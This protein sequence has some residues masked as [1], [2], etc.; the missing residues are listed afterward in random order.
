MAQV[1]REKQEHI[2]PG[3]AGSAAALELR[4]LS[5]G[6]NGRLAIA[7]INLQLRHRERMALVG[8]NGAGKSTLFKSIVGLMP[9]RSGEI[10]IH[11]K[12]VAQA[13]WVLSY[14]P[15][16]GDVDWNFPITVGEVV[17][18]GRV[19]QI[20]WFHWA[21]QR[22]WDIVRECLAMVDMLPLI[23][24]QI[25]EL[26]GGQQQRVFIARALAQGADVM[27]MDEPLSGV[28]ATTQQVFFA[29]LDDLRAR[30]VSI[31]VAMH[32]LLLAQQHFDR[33][34]LLNHTLV[35]VG[36]PDHV[37]TP[38]RLQEAYGGQLTVFESDE[39]RLVVPH[40]HGECC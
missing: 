33:I 34:A 15:Q 32:D 39:A 4:D 11:N 6:Y 24:R 12:P 5:A 37:L 3:P 14:I 1:L 10:L 29:L 8:P 7:D 30:D 13:G 40:T 20:G 21:K 26:S 16:H 36:K 18:M 31:I 22:D 23:K 28:D 17:L 38:E 2:Q 19:R 27:L 25:G 35:A 9:R